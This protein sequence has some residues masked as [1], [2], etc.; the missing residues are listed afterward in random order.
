M[1]DENITFPYPDRPIVRIKCTAVAK[2]CE[3]IPEAVLIEYRRDGTV[4]VDVP[5]TFENMCAL[6]ELDQPAV[7]TV[8][9]GY[10]FPS[11]FTP[12][13]HQFKIV[14]LLTRAKRAY[15][16]AGMG[17]GKTLSALF[18]AD[19][20]LTIGEVK[21]VL[22]V[23][24]KSLMYSAWRDDLMASILHRTHTVLYGDSKRRRKLTERDTDID[25]INF[26]GV[27]ILQD[28]LAAKQ[29]GL[30][31]IDESTAYKDPNTRR[32]KA[33]NKLITQDTWLWLLTG[34][35]TPQSAMDAYGQVKLCTPDKLPRTK[36]MFQSQV[37]YKVS[38]FIWRDRPN[39]QE[40]VRGLMK[41]AIYINKADCL[42]LPPVTRSYRLTEL[43]KPQ[44]QAVKALKTEMLAEFQGEHSVTV[45][46][47]AVLHGKLRQIYSGAVYSD[48]STALVLDNK[49]RI[50]ETKR[51]IKQ[52]KQSGD[53]SLANGKPHSKAL[54]FVPFRHVISVL[55]EELAKEFDVAVI[56]GDT[57][58]HE[59]ARILRT[60]QETDKIDVIIAIPEAFSHG[61]TATAASLTVWYAPP[62]RTEIYLQACERMDR[63]SQTQQ[64][65]IVH[66]YGDNTERKM[67]DHLIHNKDNQENLLNM[68][69]EV[70]G[71]DEKVKQAY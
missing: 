66:L 43:S 38:T 29:Y 3:R 37:Q 16:L 42:D 27:E 53:D 61:V 57:N 31:I 8:F 46:N 58:V 64:M 63:P 14:D 71:L 24:P 19:Y 41:P 65:N 62:S 44:Q 4:L 5:Y 28:E 69:R 1:S 26:D 56:T 60:F 45:A 18:A 34:T 13:Y 22:V 12:F 35:P 23:C 49:E 50:A 30:I 52:A 67:Y 40:T 68:Y 2:V 39:W 33:L 17:T 21:R 36:V 47:A 32:W 55:E 7:S 15:C 9:S 25:I 54:V 59:R 11:R 70:L 51:L 10:A 20:L 48:D 6:T